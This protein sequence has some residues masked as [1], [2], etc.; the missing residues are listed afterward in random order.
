MRR[1]I[2]FGKNHTTPPS[3][4]PPP[5]ALRSYLVKNTALADK[6]GYYFASDYA[7][8]Y[9][10]PS[11]P[12]KPI[13]IGVISLGGGLYGTYNP[14]TRTITN[15]DVQLYWQLCNIMP[16]MH[17]RVLMVPLP[18]SNPVVTSVIATQENT[19]DVATIGACCPGANVTIIMYVAPNTIAGFA[20]AFNAAINGVTINGTLVRSNI[21]SCSWGAP[22]SNFRTNDIVTL[23]TIFQRASA[24]GIPICVASGDLGASNGLPGNNVDFPASSPHVIACG[25]TTLNC[26]NLV[27]DSSTNETAWS[28]TPY[29]GGGGGGYS[30]IFSMPSWQTALKS[31]QPVLNASM[32]RAV[33]DIAMNANPMSGTKILIGCSLYVCGGT[34][35]VAPAMAAL[36]GCMDIPAFTAANLY[37]STALTTYRDITVG[38]IGGGFVAGA[39]YDC[40]TGLGTPNGKLLQTAAR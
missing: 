33:P 9:N 34:S 1:F 16:A 14:T 10:F 32:R 4:S 35:I 2:P 29:N 37:K 31:T 23:N 40:A 24:M 36:I 5:P 30:R 7:K 39:K 13:V 8:I 27:Y 20:A 22:E 26:P 15:G 19:M 6:G 21:I 12:T 17:P 3:P 11:P 25:G 18:G 28:Y 38:N